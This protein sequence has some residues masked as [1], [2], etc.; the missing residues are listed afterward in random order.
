M[1]EYRANLAD[2]GGLQHLGREG[3]RE[4]GK[5]GGN[6]L[7]DVFVKGNRYLK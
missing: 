6:G 5:E 3:G 7:M 4:G 1:D 2:K